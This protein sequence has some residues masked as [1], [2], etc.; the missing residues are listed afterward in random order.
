MK[1]YFDKKKADKGMVFKL[2][3]RKLDEG[4]HWH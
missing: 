4:K 1:K 3:L 2:M